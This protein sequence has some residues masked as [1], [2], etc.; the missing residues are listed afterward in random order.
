MATDI[1]YG[2]FMGEYIGNVVKCLST[3]VLGYHRRTDGLYT[4][5]KKLWR[6]QDDGDVYLFQLGN[7]FNLLV[8]CP[9]IDVPQ[10]EHLRKV[11][12]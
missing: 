8:E 5:F 9:R 7:N 2:I 11:V 6:T 12:S 10:P 3:E 1:K 4:I